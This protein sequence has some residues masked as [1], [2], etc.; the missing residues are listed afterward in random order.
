MYPRGWEYY[1]RVLDEHN[2]R[3]EKSKR[4]FLSKLNRTLKV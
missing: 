1:R 3:K 4:N 2:N